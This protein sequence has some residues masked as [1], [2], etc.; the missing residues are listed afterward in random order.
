MARFLTW[1]E[2]RE[3]SRDDGRHIRRT[4]WPKTRRAAQNYSP[5]IF[6]HGALWHRVAWTERGFTRRIV[7]NADFGAAEFAARDWTDEPVQDDEA[8]EGSGDTG[9]GSP[10]NPPA[11]HSQWLPGQNEVKDPPPVVVAYEPPA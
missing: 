8:G 2:A 6:A 10:E 4:A 1:R 3:L 5:W 9:F 7:A 11:A